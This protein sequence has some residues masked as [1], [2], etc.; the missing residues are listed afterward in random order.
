M[1]KY[2]LEK[3]RF[4]QVFSK[5]HV[6]AADGKPFQS[7]TDEFKQNAKATHALAQEFNKRAEAK[8]H[9]YKDTKSLQLSSM[10]WTGGSEYDVMAVNAPVTLEILNAMKKDGLIEEIKEVSAKESQAYILNNATFT[11]H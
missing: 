8:R 5:A 9:K 4:F 7:G 2:P 3:M 1:Y 11:P 6:R 10:L